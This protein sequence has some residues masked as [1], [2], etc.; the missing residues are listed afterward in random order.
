MHRSTRRL[1]ALAVGLFAFV[2]GSALLYQFGMIELEGK[3]RSF[4]DAIEWAAETLSTTGYGYD[5][6]W[7]HP[8]MVILVVA[9][10]FVGV[11]LFFLVVPIFMI[12]F[13]EERF[14]ERLP[15]EAGDISHHIVIYRFGPAVETLLQRLAADNVP[16]LVVETDEAAARAVLE[17]QQRVVFSRAEE[18]A[19]DMCKL[20]VARALVAN[21]RDEE[22]AAIVLRARQMGFRGEIFAFVE[23]PAHRRP[24]ELA[25]A[26]SAY[27]PRHII[28]AALAAHASDRISPRL[29][30]ADAISGIERRE[31]RV[32]LSSPLAGKT[33]AE[34]EIGARSGAIV[35]GQWSRS[36]L[37]SSC[38]ADLRIEPGA[39]VEIVGDAASLDRA[40]QLFG[41]SYMRKSG[42]YLI[43]G[44]GE[45]GRKVHELLTDAG[46]EV[47]V[48]ERQPVSGV[49]FVGN[50]LD[51][52]VLARAGLRDARGVVLALNSDDATLFA[53]V[54]CRDAAADVPVIARV[55]HARNIDNIYRAGAD[56]ALSISDISGEM[57][58]SRLL[59]RSRTREQHRKI[60][61]IPAEGAAGRTLAEL[62]I[63][64]QGCSVVAIARD[65][66][67]VTH[68]NAQTRI[69]PGDV[70]YVC[71]NA[72][73]LKL[74]EGL[75]HEAAIGIASGH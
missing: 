43:A 48:I 57:L 14:E 6:H 24:I 56:Y 3:S 74:L 58:T 33:L 47:R 38:G 67:F 54:I 4:W 52:S 11:F 59:G 25:G 45:V 42:P 22:N 49:D 55:N 34:A 9:V 19:L 68:L 29:P 32:P 65:G 63:R 7:S 36:R 31:L 8:A 17:M 51:S 5:S 27:T 70:L 40:A 66:T 69:E 35:V 21:G 44:F 37:D 1:V 62:P 61:R 39:L 73:A 50:V 2:V 60:S 12:P 71:G 26:T 53:T 15:R 28:A 18:D 46:E 10:Q 23:E 20:S 30:G 13:L 72:E 64:K 16:S 41:A 75:K